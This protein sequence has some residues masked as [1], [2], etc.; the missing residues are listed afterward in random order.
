MTTHVDPVCGMTIE[1][2]D[3]VGSHVHDGVRYFFCATSCLERFKADPRAFVQPAAAPPAATP[4]TIYFCPMDPEIRQIGPGVCPK[5][6]M[7]LE[8]DL[9]T[10]ASLETH[11]IPNW[12][13]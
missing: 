1:E 7:A 8:P 13:T 4:G 10:A 12:S 3:A 6:G 5:C 11:P 2:S 9:S